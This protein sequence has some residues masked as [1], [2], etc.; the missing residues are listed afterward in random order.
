MYSTFTGELI[1]PRVAKVGGK[2]YYKHIDT[3]HEDDPNWFDINKRLSI[4]LPIFVLR[5]GKISM[6]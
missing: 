2:L 6:Q 1:L 3:N 4:E 5:R